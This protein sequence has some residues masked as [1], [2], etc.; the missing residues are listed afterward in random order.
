MTPEETSK[1]MEEKM[2]FVPRMFNVINQVSDQPGK[3]FADFLRLDLC[4][5]R[6]VQKNEGIDVHR[7]LRLL[8]VA[9]LPGARGAGPQGRSDHGGDLRSRGRGN[10]R[11]AGFVPG[12]PGIPY[13]FEYAAKVL[14]VASKYTKGEPWEYMSPPE[15]RG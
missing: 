14:E 7:H 12:G 6:P 2:G 10:A 13:A 1:Y 8:E 11:A 9:A 15:F 3:T 4:R 5:R